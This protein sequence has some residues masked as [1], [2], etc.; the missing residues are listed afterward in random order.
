MSPDTWDDVRIGGGKIKKKH[1]NPMGIGLS[2][3]LDTNMAMR[4]IMYT[5][6]A[7]VQDAEGHL[8]LNSRATLEA[9]EFV[10][11]LFKEAMTDEVLSWDASFD[12]PK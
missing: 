4:A 8:V 2:S 1:G 9:V 6:G 7:S 5:F 12:Q 10:R 11:A 3:E